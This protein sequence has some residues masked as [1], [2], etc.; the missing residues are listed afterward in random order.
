MNRMGRN[1]FEEKAPRTRQAPATEENQAKV[2]G[3][4][5]KKVHVAKP[6][7]E[8]RTAPVSAPGPKGRIQKLQIQFDVDQFAD[9]IFDGKF[10]QPIKTFAHLLANLKR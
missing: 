9:T 4:V 3:P 10:S 8:N 6:A 5:V 2:E 1:P 7:T